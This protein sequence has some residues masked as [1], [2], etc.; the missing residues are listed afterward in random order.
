[1]LP[2]LLSGLVCLLQIILFI[3]FL[4]TSFSPCINC[5]INCLRHLFLTCQISKMLLLELRHEKSKTSLNTKNTCKVQSAC[6]VS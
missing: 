2:I 4:L 6:P 3:S 1:M 5:L